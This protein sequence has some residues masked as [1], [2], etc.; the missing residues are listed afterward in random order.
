MENLITTAVMLS[1][2][3]S[4]IMGDVTTSPQPEEMTMTSLP[5]D[6]MLLGNQ[7][8]TQ[9]EA[10]LAAHEAKKLIDE[11]PFLDSDPYHAIPYIVALSVALVGEC[12]SLVGKT[13]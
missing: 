10:E 6:S 1:N 4:D 9:E 11:M 3:V 2:N 8:S 7:S 12:S 13:L 5:G